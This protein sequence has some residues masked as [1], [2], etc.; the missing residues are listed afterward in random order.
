MSPELDYG[1][2]MAML[3]SKDM[4]GDGIL[5]GLVYYCQC[6]DKGLFKVFNSMNNF[7]SDLGRNHKDRERL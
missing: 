6:E 7:V 2:V 4:T 3:H 5:A 1:P